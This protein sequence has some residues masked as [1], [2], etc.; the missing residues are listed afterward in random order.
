MK[1]LVLELGPPPQPSFDNFVVGPNAAALRALGEGARVGVPIYLWGPPGVGKSHLLQ[2]ALRARGGARFDARS[3]L[4][5]TADEACAHVAVDA[6][7]A[8]DAERQHAAFALFV[9]PLAVIAA[10]RLPPVD[11]PLR[12]DL[13]TRLGGGLVFQ[14]QPPAEPEV[15][16]ALASEALRRGVGLPEDVVAFL[17]SR[18]ERDLGSLM[19]WLDALDAYSLREQRAV[20]VPLVKRLLA[21]G[22]APPVRD[23]FTDPSR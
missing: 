16:A 15:R 2:A 8:L 7:E 11:L 17:L 1:Q 4:P 23:L 5:W 18:F 3:P 14:L 21:E 9:Q 22:G 13:R 6:C 19:R 10:G 20:T 12:E